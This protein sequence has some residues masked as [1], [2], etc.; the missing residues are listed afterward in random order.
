MGPH[1]QYDHYD[2]PTVVP[3]KCTDGLARQ[4]ATLSFWGDAGETG[5][6]ISCSSG[7]ARQ[8]PG[9]VSLARITL[10]G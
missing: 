4:P 9:D 1:D 2:N 10:L 8:L 5:V 3:A 6:S 7:E